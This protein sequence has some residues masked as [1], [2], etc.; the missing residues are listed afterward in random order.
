MWERNNGQP[1]PGCAPARYR[2]HHLDNVFWESN[3]RPFRELNDAPANRATP[4]RPHPAL[5][6]IPKGCSLIP[7][8]GTYLGCGFD[9]Q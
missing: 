2:T 1:S 5:S 3:T 6:H 9:P 8:Q 4:A 7:D